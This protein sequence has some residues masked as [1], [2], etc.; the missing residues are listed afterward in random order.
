MSVYRMDD[1]RRIRSKKNKYGFKSLYDWEKK[2][3]NKYKK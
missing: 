1:F 2:F 3:Y